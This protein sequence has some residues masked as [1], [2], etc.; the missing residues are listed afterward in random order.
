VILSVNGISFSYGS[1]GVLQDVRFSVSPG[2]LLAILGPNGAGKTTLLKCINAML[3]PQT[4]TVLV[5]ERDVL[6]LS[7]G[8]IARAVGYVP[9]RS[10]PARLTVFDAVLMGRRPHIRWRVSSH[11][12]AVVDAALKRLHL[13]DLFLR[14]IDQLS[15]GELQK[16][17]IARALV[18][19]PSLMLLDEPTNSLDLK[20]Q[21]EILSLIRHVALSHGIAAVMTIHDINSAL[22]FA[23]KILFLKDKKIFAA[24]RSAEVTAET[25]EAVYGVRVKIHHIDGVPLVMPVDG[26]EAGDSPDIRKQEEGPPPTRSRQGAGGPSGRR[27]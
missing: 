15:G 1:M 7:P 22:R 27:T 19:E 12:L 26:H 17:S 25:V 14:H 10:E 23:N 9:Q 4:G 3:R 20:S 8:E 21:I 13:K 11:D 24:C 16:V 5:Q 18:Q 2:D 6:G